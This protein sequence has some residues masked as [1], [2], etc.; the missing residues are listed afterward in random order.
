MLS[1]A[2]AS[3]AAHTAGC[4][5][6]SRSISLADAG[7]SIKSEELSFLSMLGS[8]LSLPTRSHVISPRPV[9]SL[10]NNVCGKEQEVP[11]AGQVVR[12]MLWSVPS[13]RLSA[14]G[15]VHLLDTID[16][17]GNN[18]GF[19]YHC[20]VYTCSRA[21][22]VL[23]DYVVDLSAVLC[24]NTDDIRFFKPHSHHVFCY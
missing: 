7:P 23:C 9:T 13:V 19:I 6:P 21:A 15:D 11:A 22:P 10:V 12:G 3:R 5:S 17:R 20:S 14:G 18:V 8:G 2:C 16:L 1:A 24:K 4:H